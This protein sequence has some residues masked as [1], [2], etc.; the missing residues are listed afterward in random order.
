MAKGQKFAR[1]TSLEK[2]LKQKHHTPQSWDVKKV[3]IADDGTRALPFPVED[4][5]FG[6]IFATKKVYDEG[7]PPQVISESIEA[8]AHFLI[9][10]DGD[11]TLISNSSNVVANADTDTKLCLGISASQEPLVIKNRLGSLPSTESRLF[12]V[13]IHF[14]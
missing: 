5:A 13:F 12:K 10:G 4:V 6:W 14:S 11:V 8:Y 1:T 9:D 2:H 7:E 3:T